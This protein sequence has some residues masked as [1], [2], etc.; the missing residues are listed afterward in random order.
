MSPDENF[1]DMYPDRQFMKNVLYPEIGLM[2]RENKTKRVLDIGVQDYNKNNKSLFQNDDIEYWQI[3]DLSDT[4]SIN[5]HKDLTTLSCDKFLEVSMLNI[6]KKYP[7]TKNYF[8]CI[9]SIGVIGFYQF[10]SDFSHTYIQRVHD[11]LNDN[12][13]FYLQYARDLNEFGI[14]PLEITNRFELLNHNLAGEFHFLK[15]KEK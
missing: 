15:M 7:D 12:G 2:L 14:N 1:W 4:D 11:S 3:D 8:D 9:I 10:D 6:N 13:F 5:Y